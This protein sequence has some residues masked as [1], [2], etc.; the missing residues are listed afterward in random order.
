MSSEKGSHLPRKGPSPLL[1]IIPLILSIAGFV[2]AMVSLFAGSETGRMEE[3]HLIS[4]NMSNFGHDLIEPSRTT[5]S[6]PTSTDSGGLGGFIDGIMETVTSSIGD[7]LNDIANDIA[8]KLSAELGI[9]QW[10]S[11]HIMDA[12]EGEYRPNATSP[13]AGYNVTNCTQSQAA[14]QFNLTEVLDHQLAVGPLEFN[15]ADLNFPEEIDDAIKYLNSFLLAVF[16][17]YVLGASFS[18]LSF[19]LCILALHRTIGSWVPLSIIATTS[20][21]TLTLG[22]GSAITTAIAKKGESEINK[23]GDDVGI[24]ATAGGKFMILTWVAFGVMF[25]AM[26]VSIFMVH[27]VRK[28]NIGG[29]GWSRFGR[30]S[31]STV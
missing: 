31:K 29:R 12:C 30:R 8:D 3:Y 4:L 16:V 27:L 1:V 25:I 17:F 18:G 19:L 22:I 15:L 7:E 24:S 26:A 14:F 9:S 10:Y 20:L 28:N 21:A 2:L 11:L 23:Y 5:A 6:E 13:N